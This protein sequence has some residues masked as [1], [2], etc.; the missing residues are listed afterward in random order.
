MFLLCKHHKTYSTN[1]D[2]I[3]NSAWTF[4]NLFMG[5]YLYCVCMCGMYPHVYDV[6]AHSCTNAGVEISRHPWVL[7]LT[8]HY[9]LI[10]DR[11]SLLFI[12]S[13]ITIT[14]SETSGNSIASFS[15]LTIRALGTEKCATLSGFLWLWG[16]WFQM[17]ICN[18][19]TTEPS[20]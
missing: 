5:C 19:L 12:V 6:L 15:H 8:F 14:G 9:H 1:L 20:P 7:V 18:T 11:I 16:I 2:V 17:P 3:G 4:K 13:H 10:W